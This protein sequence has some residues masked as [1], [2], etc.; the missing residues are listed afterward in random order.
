MTVAGTN[1]R[2]KSITSNYRTILLIIIIH[3]QL[4]IQTN[5]F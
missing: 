4:L 1:M 5:V 3:I 2:D